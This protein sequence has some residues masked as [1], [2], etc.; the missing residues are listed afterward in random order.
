MKQLKRLC[1][2][3]VLVV[4]GL[5]AAGIASGPQRGALVVVG[6]GDLPETIVK[7]FIE[8]AGGVDAPMVVIPTAGESASYAA[9]WKGADFLRKAGCTQVTVLHTQ[10]RMEADSPQFV[11]PLQKA[12]GVWFP[13]G[14]QW[15]LVDSYLNTRTQRE[16]EKVLERGGV[17]GGTSAGATIQGSY[18]V[19][20]ARE[21][22][23]VMMAPGYETGFGYLKNVAVDQHLIKRGR[24]KDLVGVMA[25]HPELL[26][27]GV[28][29]STAIVVK[30]DR[31]EV[32]G[33]SK[34]A[35]YEAG[36]PYYFL[37]A[38]EQFDLKA[39]KKLP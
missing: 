15:R 1:M 36:K 19:R 6:G 28:D 10:E 31:F 26:G 22:N 11:A 14:R 7:T 33:A 25:A 24:E 16:L 18:L 9:D 17:I 23:T 21:G 4:G 29:E 5:W 32:I 34:V 12:K 39:R 37:S 30:G 13:G 35:I 27:I 20:G 38:R 8:L 2:P 3:W